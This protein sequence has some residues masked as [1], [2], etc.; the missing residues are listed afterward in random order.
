MP[1]DGLIMDHVDY[2]KEHPNHSLYPI[3]AAVNTGNTPQ[4]GEAE[5]IL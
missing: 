2:V 5:S 4:K 3:P 1:A